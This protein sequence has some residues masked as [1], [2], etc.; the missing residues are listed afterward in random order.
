[1]NV[2]EAKKLRKGFAKYELLPVNDHDAEFIA[3]GYLEAHG[4]VQGLVT[5]L[6]VI[7][8][9]IDESTDLKSLME[10]CRKAAL[11]ALSKYEEEA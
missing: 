9:P 6:R 3:S 11:K 4:K 2:E 8:L 10:D 1:M 7:S 5:V